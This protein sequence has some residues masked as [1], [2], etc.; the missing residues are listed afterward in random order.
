MYGE[1]AASLIFLITKASIPMK[2]VLS[3]LLCIVLLSLLAVPVFA[4]EPEYSGL[5]TSQY[6]EAASMLEYRDLFYDAESC[7]IDLPMTRAMLAGILYRIYGNAEDAGSVPTDVDTTQ[8]Y[9]AGTAWAVK[10]NI[11]PH[12]GNGTFSPDIPVTRQT[13]LVTLYRCANAYGISLSAINP[14]YTFLDG[15]LMTGEA[16]TAAFTIQRAGI[17]IEDTDGYFHYKDTVSLAEGEETIL[18]FMGSQ[19]DIL[20]ALPVSTV[21]ESEPVSDAWFED[22]CFIGHSQ[23]VGMQRYSGLSGPDYYAVVG[24]TAQNVVDYEF[25][26][27]SNGRYGS[28]SDA[29]QS[30]TYG[31]VYIMLGI[32]DSSLSDDRVE[33]FMTPMRRILDLVKETQPDA[34]IYLLSLVPVGRYTPVNELYNPESTVFYSQLVKTLSREYDTEYIDLFRMMCDKAG[35]FLSS[36]NSG[37]GIHIQPDRYPEIVEYLKRHT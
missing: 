11:V 29:L 22:V 35:Y 6:C 20:T 16:Q 18:R 30:K 37:D 26:E 21:A 25:Y 10:K 3:L 36:F 8:W 2:R 4:A 32:N 34:V 28:L 9:A 13:L 24:H 31:K 15:G 7:G 1:P 19:K 33:K 5:R 14:W 17:M 12:D 27:L 23:I